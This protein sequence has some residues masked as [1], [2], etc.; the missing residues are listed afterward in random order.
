MIE[1]APE[2]VKGYALGKYVLMIDKDGFSLRDIVKRR[3]IIDASQWVEKKEIRVGDKTFTI[4][5]EEKQV[6]VEVVEDKY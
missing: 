5:F 3:F 1:K 6:A 2:R 4:K